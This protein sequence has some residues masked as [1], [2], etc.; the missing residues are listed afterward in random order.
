MTRYHIET[1]KTNLI[2]LLEHYAVKK[3]HAVTLIDC[4]MEADMRGVHTH[5][6]SV[7]P[8]YVNKIRQNGFDLSA[9]IEICRSTAAFTIVNANN[10]IGAVSAKA[11]MMIAI[12]KCAESGMHAVFCRNANTF[13]PGFYYSKIAADRKQIGLC[14][15]NSPSAMPAWGGDQKILGTNPFS[16]A[17]PSAS[18]P[19]V[20]VDM[21]TSIVAKSKINEIRKNGGQLPVGWALDENGIP[22]TDPQRAINGMIL[23][24]AGHKGSAIAMS[25]DIL[26]G[27]LSGAG[28]L[29]HIDRFYSSENKCMNVGQCFIAI[30]PSAVSD[31]SFYEQ[32]DDY[33][34]QVHQSGKHVLYPGERGNTAYADAILNGVELLDETAAALTE[35]LSSNHI[36]EALTE[37][38]R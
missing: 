22:T 37:H 7:L 15:C 19:P 28:Y 35:L 23:P 31:N 12:E 25:I 16:I 1:L 34:Q 13:G 6:L 29:N 24:M 2:R 8:A 30:D 10:Q 32:M 18:N 38:V 27:V 9:E 4:M 14:F 20:I 36:S 26:A 33:I 17:F 21:A 5:G 3:E 11:C